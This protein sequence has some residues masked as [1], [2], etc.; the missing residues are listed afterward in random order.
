M[1]A[2]LE[3][4]L[5]AT[6]TGFRPEACARWMKH[7]GIEAVTDLMVIWPGLG[8]AGAMAKAQLEIEDFILTS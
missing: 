8:H 2:T 1:T 3:A 4:K 6:R 7:M 5:L